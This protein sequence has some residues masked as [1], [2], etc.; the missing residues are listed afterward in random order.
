MGLMDWLRGLWSPQQEEE[1]APSFADLEAE[2]QEELSERYEEVPE[3]DLLAALDDEAADEAGET[4]SDVLDSVSDFDVGDASVDDLLSDD[5][6][7]S[8]YEQNVAQ[9]IDLEH[10]DDHLKAA[11]VEEVTGTTLE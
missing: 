11:G 7:E 5:E 2:A 1:D 8:F 6:G 9:E 3:D 4:E 10:S